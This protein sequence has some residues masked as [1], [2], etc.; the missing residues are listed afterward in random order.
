MEQKNMILEVLE[1]LNASS[2]QIQFH[3]GDE[4]KPDYAHDEKPL[5]GTRMPD[6]VVE[7]ESAG[8]VSAIL[9]AC[10][11]AGIAVTVRGA[12]TGLVGGA[13][14]IEG[15]LLLSTTRMNKILTYDENAMTVTVQPGVLLS[16]LVADAA[17]HG[18]MYGPDPGEK[19]ATIGGN[20]ATNASGPHAFKYGTT[21]ENVLNLTVV[22]ADG[23][24]V[25]LGSD[26]LK[27]NSG[28]SLMHLMLGSEGTLGVITELTLKLYPTPAVTTSF[29][30]PYM[31]M[32]SCIAAAA[33]IRRANLDPC[34]LEFMDSDIVE[35]STK[36]TGNPVFPTEVGG[37]KPEALLLAEFTANSD[38]EM[39]MFMEAFAEIAEETECLD[40][41]V[42]DSPT[43]KKDVQAALDAFHTAVE[44]DAKICDES[45]CA[46]PPA[47]LAEYMNFVREAAGVLSLTIH[48]FGH[49]ADGNVH[50]YVYNND[51]CADELKVK[52][53]A[54]M[55]ENY[56][57]VAELGGSVSAEHGIGFGKKKYLPEVNA[58][59]MRGVK[60]AFD[61]KGILNPG[62]IV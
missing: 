33:A 55:I 57:K 20:A 31:D 25:K 44:A 16:D 49:A 26:A 38:D 22:L 17:A 47:K 2:P 58:R 52:L 40:I 4:I 43:L 12:G 41:L 51:M 62:K 7:P 46:V 11:D 18:F 50:V 28:Y 45:N 15:G 61:P 14:A 24:I 29:I 54:F 48:M 59:L 21:R 27:D 53:E 60:A 34:M 32:E 35:F 30:L 19:T 37:E 10:N 3:T 39:D 9:K 23:E 8:E 5:Y 1:A 13:V 42:V 36:F 6:A 56:A